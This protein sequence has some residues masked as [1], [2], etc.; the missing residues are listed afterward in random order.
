M[1]EEEPLLEVTNLKTQ[2]HTDRGVVKAVDGVSFTIQE[3]ET[4]GFV[5]E[6]GAGKSVT[7][8]SIMRLIQHP[9]RI[10]S[11][12]IRFRGKDIRSMSEPELRS[13]RGDEI[14]MVFQDPMTALNP[15]YTV[16]TQI[17]DVIK[18]HD[19]GISR[20]DA[21]NRTIRLLGDVGIPDPAQ[22]VDDYPH[23]F[24]GG[25][26][27][28][29]LIAMAIS[30]GPEL[31]IADEPTTAL[32]VTIQ[33]QILELLK[34]LQEQ[35]D[36]AIHLITHDMGVIAEVC[37]RV[38]VMYGGKIVEEGP[39]EEIFDAPKHPY[40]IGLMK[41]IPRM[42]DPRDRL[43]AIPGNMPGLINT[44]SGCSFRDRCP[45]AKPECAEDEPPLSAVSVDDVHRSACVRMDEIDLDAARE[46]SS[47]ESTRP[48]R[49]LGETLVSID[50]LQKYFEPESQAWYE[51]WLGT[52]SYVHAVED[53]SFSIR[54]GET[55][56]LVGESG[57]GKTT[58][59]RTV[60][61]LY[62]PT[63]GRVLYAGSDL[64]EMQ[65]RELKSA[66]SDLQMIFQDPFSSLNPRKT[67]KNIIGRPLEV[68][69]LVDNE[70]EKE[71]RVTEL[72]DEVGLKPSH[73]N[74]YPHEFS[75]GQKQRIGLA[76]ALAVEP[77]FIVADEP[78]S[79]LDVSVQAK[80]LN[81]LMDLQDEYG[82][83]FLFIAHDLNVVQHIAD[84]IAVMYL[85]EVVEIGPTDQ[86][87]EPPHH[88]Y[89][90]VLL[91]SIPQP[92]PG[93]IHEKIE[94]VGELPSPINPPSG[95]RF[96]TRCPYAMDACKTQD[97]SHVPVAS[98]HEIHCHLFDE[99]VMGDES[100]I[101]EVVDSQA[102]FSGKNA[103]ESK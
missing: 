44:P 94:P 74:R 10:E 32:D 60:L 5:G 38:S 24:S 29:A 81:K 62:E 82:L 79:A 31:L 28:R 63:S 21:R 59:G 64:T 1:S 15:A 46:I 95:C 7:A 57:C 88:P 27:Q 71:A 70:D 65:K 41:A 16:G 52:P 66:R 99:Q 19:P 73:L 67:V 103:G 22:R 101:A 54:R 75:G 9:G 56:G 93:S 53:V 68:H 34:D 26:R 55:L 72:L 4:H 87:F 42:N 92:E 102:D 20:E 6:S 91:S 51:K 2:F 50:S 35:Y 39:M 14:A 80:I 98:D 84:R 78:V 100:H 49:D 77:D 89:T 18:Q 3:G 90:E 86:I 36:L 69:G 23:Q 30:C 96:H 85:G 76:R 48:V 83:T 58:L 37:D 43:D 13:V 8:R 12:E 97:P 61:R 47:G 17:I 11:G 40:T 25:M 33:A 45:H